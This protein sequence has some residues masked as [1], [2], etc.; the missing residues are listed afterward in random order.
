[1]TPVDADPLALLREALER[2]VEVE[3]SA[4]K[5]AVLATVDAGA[6]PDARV[7]N[8]RRVD[9]SGL[10]FLTRLDS[11]KARQLDRHP[12]AALCF[13]WKSLA[14]QIRV[15]GTV[16]RLAAHEADAYWT[17]RSRASQLG[18]RAST[19][20]EVLTDKASLEARFADQER[21]HPESPVPRPPEWGGFRLIPRSMEFWRQGD[22]WLHERVRYDRDG[23]A[24][25]A[26]RLQP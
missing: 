4:P 21:D 17:R 25:R 5:A 6:R 12:D 8:V 23:D 1:M 14:E 22:P 20:S 2:A 18:D 11:P 15:R 9:A 3:P 10:A 24:W 26:V 13:H 16:E 19:Q 7:V